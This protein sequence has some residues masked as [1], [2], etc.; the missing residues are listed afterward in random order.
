[1]TF[2][3]WA[4]QKRLLFLMLFLSILLFFSE[5]LVTQVLCWTSVEFFFFFQSRISWHRIQKKKKTRSIWTIKYIIGNHRGYHSVQ[6]CTQNQQKNI[7]ILVFFCYLLLRS[8]NTMYLNIYYSNWYAR[9]RCIYTARTR[10]PFTAVQAVDLL[11]FFF[12]FRR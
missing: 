5:I 9:T 12:F 7:T 2:S 8:R 10:P 11:L 6:L 1:M 3:L 4:L